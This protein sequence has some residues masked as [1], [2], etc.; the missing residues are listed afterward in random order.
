ML[1]TLLAPPALC[2]KSGIDWFGRSYGRPSKDIV[3]RNITVGTGHGISVGSEM[4]GGVQNVTFEDIVMSETKA[5]PRIKSQR[6]RGGVIDG[7]VYRN[8]VASNVHTMVEFTLNYH[9]G[10]APTNAT[11]TP[12]LRNV[13]LENSECGIGIVHVTTRPASPKPHMHSHLH[14]R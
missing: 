5:G 6:G 14:R 10:L 2:V 7:I 13:L 12:V 3:F 8:I 4:S 9:S 11:A 1:T